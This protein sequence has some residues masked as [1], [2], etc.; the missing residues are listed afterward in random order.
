MSLKFSESGHPQKFDP[1][2]WSD[3][4]RAT[5]DLQSKLT[6]MNSMVD[7]VAKARLIKNVDS[8]RR[9]QALARSIERCGDMSFNKAE[10]AAR[11]DSDYLK[12]LERLDNDL[13]LAERSHLKWSAITAEIDSIRTLISAAKETIRNA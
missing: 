12:D 1:A 10:M 3:L 5:K 11:V 7:E 2:D 9:K 6:I 8:E 4:F 13:L